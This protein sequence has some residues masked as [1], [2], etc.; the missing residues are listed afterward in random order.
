[1]KHNQI[2][3]MDKNTCR[4][5]REYEVGWREIINFIIFN[6]LFD[7][8]LNFQAFY[9]DTSKNCIEKLKSAPPL[10]HF[11]LRVSIYI[12]TLLYI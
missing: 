7:K 5:F 1:M 12:Y 8:K 2:M 6:S 11:L 9:F 10:R 4:S 3:K